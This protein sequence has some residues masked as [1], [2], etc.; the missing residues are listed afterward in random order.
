MEEVNQIFLLCMHV[1][2]DKKIK[3]EEND[4]SQGAEDLYINHEA[5]KII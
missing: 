1:V 4:L 3:Q 2:Y 5:L